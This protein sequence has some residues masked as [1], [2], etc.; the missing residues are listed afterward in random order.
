MRETC[1][2]CRWDFDEENM[3]DCPHCGGA[4]CWRCRESHMDECAKKKEAT[5]GEPPPPEP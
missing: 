4:Y 1:S 3:L 5:S 2:T